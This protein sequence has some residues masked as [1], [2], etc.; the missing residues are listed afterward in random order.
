M[1]KMLL[2][3]LILLSITAG[4]VFATDGNIT[5]T[6]VIPDVAFWSLDTVK[7]MICTKTCYIVYRKTDSDGNSTGKEITVIFRNK[8][9]DPDTPEDETTTEF[10]QLINAINNNNSLK[11]TISNAV[12]LKLDI[13]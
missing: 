3:V 11:T 6:E 7:F 10:T 2:I 4:K 9:D 1:R 5:N 8:E 13:Q 12:K